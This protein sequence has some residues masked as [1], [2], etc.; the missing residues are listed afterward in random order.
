MATKRTSLLNYFSPKEAPSHP[1]KAKLNTVVD[2][3]NSEACDSSQTIT[4][5][6]TCNNNST[7]STVTTN[8]TPSDIALTPDSY[9]IQPKDILFPVTIIGSKKRC[10]NPEWCKKYTWLEYSIERD[11]VFCFAC[12]FFGSSAVCRSR[13]EVTFTSIGFRNWKNATGTT[14]AL[15]KHNSSVSHKESI[16]I[17][18]QSIQNSSQNKSIADRMHSSHKELVQNNHHY[19]KGIIDVLLLCCHQ[20]IAMRGHNESDESANRGNFVE[21]LHVLAR[22]DPI[23]QERLNNGPRNAMYTSPQVQNILLSIMAELVQQKICLATKKAGYYSILADE[24]KDISKC[25]QLSIVIRYVEVETGIVYERFLTYV[26]AKSQTAESLSAYILDTLSKFGLDYNFMVSQGYDGASVMSGHCSGVQQR[27]KNVAPQAMY[28]HCYAHCLNLVLVDC[29]KINTDAAN[30]FMLIEALY[31]FLTT[32]KAHT[33]YLEKQKELHPTQQIHELVRLSDTRWSSRWSS[34]N[35]LCRTFDSVLATLDAI[36]NGLDKL[37]AVEGG[38]LLLQVKSFKF[39]VQLIVFDRLLT[40]THCLSNQLQ[41]IELDIG[42]A[43]DLVISTKSTLQIF[44]SDAEWDKVFKYAQDVA[45]LYDINEPTQRPRRRSLPR[46]Y[47]DEIILD[48]PSIAHRNSNNDNL[49]TSFYFPILDVM[50]SELNRRFSDEAL[51]IMRAVQCCNPSSKSFLEPTELLLLATK[52]N[53]NVDLDILTSEC[54]QAI[55][56]LK[57]SSERDQTAYTSI[58]EVL[59]ELGTLKEA[60]PNVVKLLQISLT[61]VVSSASCER[62]FS[63]LKRIKN[64]LRSKMTEDRLNHVAILSIEKDLSKEV[65]YEQIID[66]FIAKDGN[67]RIILS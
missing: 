14:G 58:S 49:K 61:I 8:Q 48:T 57:I 1:K 6:S 2:S 3:E 45:K 52:Y 7:S 16:L 34:I 67:R 39:I 25:E 27:I 56:T 50:L 66:S 54:T 60:F 11:A 26:E 41:S 42:K 19:M 21:I 63:A 51:E 17:W 5:D 12:R 62:S 20:E 37:K 24:T 10:F 29:A 18:K 13:P 47:E 44:R 28:I 36:K 30:F 31:V 65:D 40:T 32:S 59:Q 9:P 55:G 23:I 33:I 15:A 35:A 38:G 43:G 46:R 22:H 53:L 64:Y 4:Q